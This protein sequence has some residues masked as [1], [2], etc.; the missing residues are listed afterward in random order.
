MATMLTVFLHP[1][2]EVEVRHHDG[3]N[4]GKITIFELRSPTGGI[5]DTVSFHTNSLQQIADIGKKIHKL[6][7]AELKKVRGQ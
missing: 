4:G 2:T 6:A 5:Q 7:M 1:E 3:N